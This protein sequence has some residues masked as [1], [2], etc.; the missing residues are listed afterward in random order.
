MVKDQ[1]LF[2]S[3]QASDQF[4]DLGVVDALRFLGI[5]KV[6]DPG[7]VTDKAQT[8]GVERKAVG[9]RPGVVNRHGA[10]GVA[11][12]LAGHAGWGSV[13]IVG[14]FFC[15]IVGQIIH[16]GCHISQSVSVELLHGRAL[17]CR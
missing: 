3:G 15:H 2:G 7:L 17:L 6:A 10:G 11:T 13:E 14:R 1:D 4:G 9:N 5:V 12:V 16:L 8:L